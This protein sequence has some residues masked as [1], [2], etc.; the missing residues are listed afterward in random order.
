MSQPTYRRGDLVIVTPHITP[1]GT[2]RPDGTYD[3]HRFAGTV[4]AV[5]TYP[6]HPDLPTHY[7]VAWPARSGVYE[8]HELRPAGDAMRYTRMP[9]ICPACDQVTTADLPDDLDARRVAPL[10]PGAHDCTAAQ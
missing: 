6:G 7:D 10:V 5:T 8:A 9:V 1:Q 3:Q 4:I 2:P